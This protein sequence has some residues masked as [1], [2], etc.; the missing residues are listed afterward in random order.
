MNNATCFQTAAKLL[1]TYRVIYMGGIPGFPGILGRSQLSLYENGFSLSSEKLGC[2]FF[3]YSNVINFKTI[4]ERSSY[5]TASSAASFGQ[6][7]IHIQYV[8]ENEETHAILLEMFSSVFLPKQAADCKAMLDLMG[9]NHIFKQFRS[10][11][12]ATP[13]SASSDILAQIERLAA[14]H[15]SGALTDEEFQSKKTELL[16][17]L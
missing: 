7:H 6:R 8:D 3:H 5:A 16:N 2:H 4:R 14:L 10:A 17:K 12:S 13:T 11:N 9:R 1:A 15:Q